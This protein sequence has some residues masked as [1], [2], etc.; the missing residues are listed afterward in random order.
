MK[1]RKNEMG[2][3]DY[4]LLLTQDWSIGE[5]RTRRK[6][7]MGFCGCGNL[8]LRGKLRGVREEEKM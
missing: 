5:R 3:E 2:G 4:R 6:E 7:Q 8:S 1:D